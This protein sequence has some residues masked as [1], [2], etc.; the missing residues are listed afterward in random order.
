VIA[1]GLVSPLLFIFVVVAFIWVLVVSIWLF[2]HGS[3]DSAADNKTE[4]PA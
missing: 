4:H 1:V 2:I 3:K